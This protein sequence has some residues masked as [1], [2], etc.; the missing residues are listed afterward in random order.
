MLLMKFKKYLLLPMLAF[1]GGA[2]ISC[3]SGG[4]STDVDIVADP[5]NVLPVE[6]KLNDFAII[7]GNTSLNFLSD[8]SLSLNTPTFN[9]AFMEYT[10][11]NEDDTV[12]ALV[13]LT[14]PYLLI[15]DGNTPGVVTR[16]NDLLADDTSA[17]RMLLD[18]NA[19]TQ[20]QLLNAL[21]GLNLGV[22]FDITPGG[23][24]FIV[25]ALY[26]SFGSGITDR[27]AI[28]GSRVFFRR[29]DTP[30]TVVIAERRVISR[31]QREVGTDIADGEFPD[32]AIVKL[33]DINSL[34]ILID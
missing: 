32:T 11:D 34:N 1:M 2:I 17:F 27:A 18:N 5:P 13:G 12:G 19:T 14:P 29:G 26:L 4:S 6:F 22:E 9:N 7:N 28:V 30:P 24:L 31:Q 33:V 10:Y 20:L 3:D 15:T 16:I 8:T 25:D 21:N 23:T